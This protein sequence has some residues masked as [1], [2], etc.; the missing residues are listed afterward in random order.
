[1]IMMHALIHRGKR[2]ETASTMPSTY[3]HPLVGT[4]NREAED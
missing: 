1:M 4:L 2:D 3:S